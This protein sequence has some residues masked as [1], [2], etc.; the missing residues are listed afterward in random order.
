MNFSR[1]REVGQHRWLS[2]Y[3]WRR[4]ILFWTGAVVV[5]LAAVLFAKAADFAFEA[6]VSSRAAAGGAIGRL[7]T[8]LFAHRFAPIPI[9]D[10]RAC[11]PASSMW[12]VGPPWSEIC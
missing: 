11:S 6:D 1:L 5:G 9:S 3:H 2:P 7:W 12:P 4:R 10:P 8:A